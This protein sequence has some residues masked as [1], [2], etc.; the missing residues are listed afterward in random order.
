MISLA[1]A[2]IVLTIESVIL[3]VLAFYLLYRYGD[4][5]RQ[6][7]L[8]T[9]LTLCI[10][11]LSFFIVFLLPIDVSS[12]SALCSTSPESVPDH[13]PVSPYVCTYACMRVHMCTCVHAVSC[14]V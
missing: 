13:W 2:P 14:V 1:F 7:I 9:V 11:F 3:L 4:I 5:R 12:V 8:V 10:W 6:N